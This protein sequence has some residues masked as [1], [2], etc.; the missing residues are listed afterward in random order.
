MRWNQLYNKDYKYTPIIYQSLEVWEKRKIELKEQ[1]LISAGLWPMP[2]KSLLIT[3]IFD[4]IVFDDFSIEKVIFESYPSFYVTGNLYRPVGKQGLF[5]AIL[6][7]HG[8]WKNGRLEH[9]EATDIPTRC[10][11]FAKMGFIAFTFDMLGFTDSKQVTHKYGG[12]IQELWNIGTF[13][14]QLWNSI[15]CIDFLETL[16]DVD[17]NKIGCTGAS[18]GGAQTFFL[19]A[20]DEDRK[21]VV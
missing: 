1:I 4:R 5:P 11:N 17:I 9:S 7:P 12:G 14:V 16:P 19:S 13:G 15:R 8:H 20:I 10:A 18:G 3:R 21:S 2:Q 6:N